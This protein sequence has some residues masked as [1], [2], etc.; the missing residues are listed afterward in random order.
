MDGR[1]AAGLGVVAVEVGV[2]FC[3]LDMGTTG[4]LGEIERGRERGREW[5]GGKKERV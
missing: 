4:V 2:V 5:G 1:P 3:S